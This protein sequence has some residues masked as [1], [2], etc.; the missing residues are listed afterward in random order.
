MNCLLRNRAIWWKELWDRDLDNVSGFGS[1]TRPK[2]NIFLQSI[3]L[4]VNHIFLEMCQKV[5]KK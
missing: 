1:V 4:N 5:R 3:Q 2:I